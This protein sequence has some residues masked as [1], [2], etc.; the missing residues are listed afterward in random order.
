MEGI[1]SYT[2]NRNLLLRPKLTLGVFLPT[3]SPQSCSEV[4]Q[5]QQFSYSSDGISVPCAVEHWSSYLST[6]RL[7]EDRNYSRRINFV[8]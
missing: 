8:D 3:F 7:G 4:R 1:S 6:Y 5:C 2:C